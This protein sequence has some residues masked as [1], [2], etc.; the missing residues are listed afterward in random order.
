M[1]DTH[2]PDTL[3]LFTKLLNLPDITVTKISQSSNEREVTFTVKS[4]RDIIPCRECGK[5]TRG[6]GVGRPLHLRHLSLLGKETYIEITP[7]RGRCDVC[8]NNPTTTERL[9][10]YELNSKMTKPY[11]Q[12]LLF[13][14]INSTIADVSRKEQVDYHCIEHLIKTYIET[15]VDFSSIETLGVMGLDEISLKKGYRDF[16]TLITY[17]VNDKV[18]ILGVVSG[19][20]K[21]EIKAFLHKIPSRLRSTVTAICCDL[22][23]GYMNACKE[24]FENKIP[25]VADRFH[26]RKLYR[27]SLVNMRKSELKRLKAQLTD[28][29]YADLKKAIAILRKQKD[30]FTEEEKPEVE[31]L[32]KLSPKLKEAYQF[33]RELSG[34]FDSHITPEEAKIKM[35]EWIDAVTQSELNCFNQFIKTLVKYQEQ[36]C[37]YFI[38]R[39]NSGF[40]EGFN[41]KVKVLKRRCYGLSS[42]T[43]LFQRLIL[44]TLGL[45][46][47]APG[48][49]AF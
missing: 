4:T 11:E 12:Y 8:D 39:N 33:S 44:D 3:A 47:F 20:E 13:E 7:R 41:N 6:H 18:S 48:M 24:V 43:A 29:D 22:Y 28:T 36:I 27:K 21:A 25:I 35:T 45:Q 23:D 42:I 5:P 17:R 26:V 10:W 16:I 30:Y 15:E 37:N 40:V 38:N 14:L 46:R 32:F 19:R 2:S 34:L 9:S 31:K 49:A 1:Q